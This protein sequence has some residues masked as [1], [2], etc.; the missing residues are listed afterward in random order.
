MARLPQVSGKELIR[1]LQSFG[2]VV[3]RRRGSH[4]RLRKKTGAGEHNITVPDHPTV[5]KGTLN[6]I[7]SS[8]G[9]WNGIPKSD[10]LK[11]LK[12]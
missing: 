5:A 11:R 2:Y 4:A 6:D 12:S 1:F 10:L 9:I 3:L 8:V 7:L